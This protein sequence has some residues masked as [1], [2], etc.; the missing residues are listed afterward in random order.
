MLLDDQMR[1]KPDLRI[2]HPGLLRDGISREL[3]RDRRTALPG[4]VAEL[5]GERESSF[6]F[7]PTFT[8]LSNLLVKNPSDPS[9]IFTSP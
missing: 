4:C 5:N 1:H 7:A 2:I 3:I 8:G 6:E 9:L